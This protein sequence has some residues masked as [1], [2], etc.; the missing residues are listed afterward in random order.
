MTAPRLDVPEA[1]PD[2]AALRRASR[3][4]G[5][6]I[7]L[8]STIL[9]VL[10]VVAA[11]AFVFA[12]LDPTELFRGGRHES[13]IDVGGL[14]IVVA[15]L[16]I[17]AAAI[18]LAGLLSWFATR[19]AVRPL[20]EALRLQRTFVS[21]ASHELR[22]PIAVLDARLQYLQRGLAIDD[23]AAATVAELRRDAGTLVQI[24]N[25]LLVT[26]EEG[27]DAS[28]AGSSVEMEPVVELAVDSI[29]LL[30]VE[31]RVSITLDSAPVSVPLP[32]ASIHRC[33]VALLDN[34][35]RFAP[36]GS[37][38]IVT[39][40]AD[41]GFAELR[42]SDAGP[43]IT[44]L[45]PSQVFERFA[46]GEG[47]FTSPAGFGIGLALVKDTVTRVGGVAAVEKTGP[48]GTTMLLQIPRSRRR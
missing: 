20:G 26:A 33:V 39:L 41:H 46:R 47:G 22:T 48:D 9:V 12:H 43:G 13:T 44:G 14:D 45:E 35:L 3:T 16:G 6:Q 29:R 15:A 10:V 11:F 25:D 30:A 37:T 23:P 42:V 28:A 1:D 7:A 18:A 17:G 8:A 2:A 5:V 27:G 31:R 36:D 38:I 24:V 19:R 4:V 32:A 34:A 21:N 40:G